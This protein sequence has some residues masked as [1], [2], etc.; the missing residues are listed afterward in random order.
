M[1]EFAQMNQGVFWLFC[2]IFPAIILGLI[3]LIIRADRRAR[4]DQDDDHDATRN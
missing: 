2:V 4:T 3:I 1:S